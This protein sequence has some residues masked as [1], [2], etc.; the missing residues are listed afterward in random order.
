MLEDHRTG[1]SETRTDD[2]IECHHI[3]VV[4]LTLDFVV[5]GMI[6]VV[7]PIGLAH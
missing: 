3:G 2:N 1:G 5:S 6:M 4:P 7:E